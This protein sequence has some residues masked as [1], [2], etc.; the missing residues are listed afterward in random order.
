MGRLRVDRKIDSGEV[1][2]EK[3]DRYKKRLEEYENKKKQRK[4]VGKDV[5]IDA[6]KEPNKVLIN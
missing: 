4:F 2:R 6:R 1:I 5:E 3:F